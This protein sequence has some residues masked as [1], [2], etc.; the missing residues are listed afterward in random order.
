MYMIKSKKEAVLGHNFMIMKNKKYMFQENNLIIFKES[1]SQLDISL[2]KLYSD[3]VTDTKLVKFHFSRSHAV[4]FF[5]YRKNKL[6]VYFYLIISQQ[7]LS[8]LIY[9]QE[10]LIKEGTNI[11][12]MKKLDSINKIKFNHDKI[13]KYCD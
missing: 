4:F 5:L 13:F 9:K 8:L 12:I 6:G 11:L 2:L 1:N 7:E 3:Y 10:F